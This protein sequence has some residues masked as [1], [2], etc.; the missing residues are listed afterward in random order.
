MNTSSSEHTYS[1]PGIP[2]VLFT[3]QMRK[4]SLIHS[5]C[6]ATGEKTCACQSVNCL[7]DLS[8]QLQV[9][10]FFVR[11]HNDN[12]WQTIN[13]DQFCKRDITEKVGWK[14]VEMFA[15]LTPYM[16]IFPS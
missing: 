2:H 15:S 3:S 11:Y 4:I 6:V 13:I 9:I 10:L 7:S 12:T 14:I 16:Y 8:F 1:P 5:V